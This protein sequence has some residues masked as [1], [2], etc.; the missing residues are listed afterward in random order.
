MRHVKLVEAG[1]GT[2]GGCN[3][4]DGGAAGGGEAVG[5][6]EFAGDGCDREFAER[7]VNLVYS[8]GSEANGSGYWK[9]FR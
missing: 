9:W 5:K 7:M 2:V 3:G 8:Y 6:V 1:S 4:F